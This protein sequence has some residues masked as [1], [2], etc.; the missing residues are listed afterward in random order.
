MRRDTSLDWR[1][2]FENSPNRRR[3]EKT[4][5]KNRHEPT[6]PGTVSTPLRDVF[7]RRSLA[8]L[9]GDVVW[10]S[11]RSELRPTLPARPLRR[12]IHRAARLAAQR[13]RGLLVIR[14]SGWL[15]DDRSGDGVGGPLRR[16][17][18]GA[19]W[20]ARDQGLELGAAGASRRQRRPGVVLGD[21]LDELELVHLRRLLGLR[22]RLQPGGRGGQG[23]GLRG[24]LGRRRRCSGGG[25]LRTSASSSSSFW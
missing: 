17:Y 2:L 19:G 1:P 7:S 9:F 24:V 5:R 8:T 16:R 21:G 11:D 4:S 14:S 22:L 13:S 12:R 18:R 23:R 15:G 25:R 20:I 6:S 10:F 3:H